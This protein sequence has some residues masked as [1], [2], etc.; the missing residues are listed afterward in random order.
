MKDHANFFEKLK[1]FSSQVAEIP[2]L[3][4]ARFLARLQIRHTR[5]GELLFK[6]G[7]RSNLIGFVAKGLIYTI[8]QNSDGKERVKNFAWE[9]RL[10]SPWVSILDGKPASFSA[11]SL[12]PSYIVAMDGKIFKE[13]FQNRHICW[14]RFSRA[15]TERVLFERE[16]REREFL[17]CSTFE[18]YQEFLIQYRDITERIPQHLIASYLGITPVALSRLLSENRTQRNDLN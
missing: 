6:E 9:G 12:E 2:P 10:I 16:K 4:W 8:Y 1:K 15:C 3:E 13:E 7:E 18:R 17:M 14:E 5:K 11:I